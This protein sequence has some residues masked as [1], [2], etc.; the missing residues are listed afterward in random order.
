MPDTRYRTE[1]M[2]DLY[3]VL[4]VPRDASKDIIRNTYRKLARE[5]HPDATGG[6]KVKAARFAEVTAAYAILYD[7]DKRKE[8]DEY[9]TH[10]PIRDRGSVFG[11]LF[12]DLVG[13][14]SEEGIHGGN[15]D[16]VMTGFFAAVKD[17]Q[18][19]FPNRVKE[20]SSKP[21]SFLNFVEMILDEDISVT[22]PKK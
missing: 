18:T 3:H 16:E 4:G 19:N 8:Y 11:K 1:R 5:L 13:Q 15:I 20:A 2:P 6:D 22:P 10:S 21:S 14:V 9:T 12:D 17:I 7:D